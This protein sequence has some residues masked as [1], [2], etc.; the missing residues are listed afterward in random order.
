MKTG[1]KPHLVALA[2]A[3]KMGD[4]ARANYLIDLFLDCI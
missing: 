1:S 3:V 4:M 2:V